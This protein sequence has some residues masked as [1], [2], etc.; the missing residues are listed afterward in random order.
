MKIVHTIADLRSQLNPFQ[1][2][3]FVAT[4]GNLH[5]GHIAL[6]K[7]VKPLGDVTVAST[8]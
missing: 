2:P 7:Q 4:M 3:A 6:V 8:L 1:R 5:E